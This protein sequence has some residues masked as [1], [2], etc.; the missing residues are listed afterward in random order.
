MLPGNMRGNILLLTMATTGMAFT[1]SHGHAK[2][3][4][5]FLFLILLWG[6][7]FVSYIS[8]MILYQGFKYTKA[9]TYD[10]CITII[11]G[12]KAGLISNILVFLHTCGSVTSTYCFTFKLLLSFLK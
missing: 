9:K 6:S 11:L 8:N 3:I 1:M 5:L 7:A 12:Q 2:N 4:G 10:E